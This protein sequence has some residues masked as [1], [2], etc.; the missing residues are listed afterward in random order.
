MTIIAKFRL[1]FKRS[2]ASVFLRSVISKDIG[3]GYAKW[4]STRET[5]ARRLTYKKIGLPACITRGR[6]NRVTGKYL[7]A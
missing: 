2:K 3:A 5:V 7:L 4:T 6:V 1:E